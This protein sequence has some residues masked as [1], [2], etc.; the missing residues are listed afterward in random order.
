M[1]CPLS[2]KRN[3]TKQQCLCA[4]VYELL[5]ALLALELALPK[6]EIL[7]HVRLKQYR[8]KVFKKRELFQV[9]VQAPFRQGSSS[10]TSPKIWGANCLILS[11]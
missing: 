9:M 7:K 10:I 4:A 11:E 5:A 8:F 3:I 2:T 1:L 6:E